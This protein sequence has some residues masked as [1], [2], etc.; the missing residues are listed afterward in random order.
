MRKR[1][2]ANNAVLDVGFDLERPQDRIERKTVLPLGCG[3]HAQFDQGC[4]G[5]ERAVAAP[6]KHARRM[7]ED[8]A[9]GGIVADGIGE[10]GAQHVAMAARFMQH[11]FMQPGH[12]SNVIVCLFRASS[13][14]EWRGSRR[15]C[16][17]R[18]AMMV[19]DAGNDISRANIRK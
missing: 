11:R 7:Q 8:N 12:V 17:R 4:G 2:F 6:V 14:R 19:V 18:L 3:N 10:H 9:V 1:T 5:G 15:E 13:C 16:S